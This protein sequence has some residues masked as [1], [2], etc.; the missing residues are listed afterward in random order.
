MINKNTNNQNISAG[1]VTALTA[2]NTEYNAR[3]F[4]GGTE[5]DCAIVRITVTKGSCGDINAFTVGNVV[6]S[7]LIAEVKGLSTQVK[8]K[9]LTAQIG[10]KVNGSFEYV[11]LGY[12]T[13]SE[14]QQTA[15]ST[16]ITAYGATI[17][18]TGNAFNAPAT[19]TLANIASSIATS[20][21]ALAGRTVNVTFGS[22]ITTS[23][24]ITASMANLTVYQ[25]LMI[26][27]SVVGGYAIDTY[28]GNI[29][30]CRF[31]DTATLARDTSTMKN[32]PVVDELNFEVNGV[33][34]I[35]EEATEDTE[36]VQFPTTPTGDE[37]LI[38]QN[39]YMT[40]D[41]YT[42]Y[43]ATLVNYEY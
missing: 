36:A 35:V 20:V 18:K 5:L 39:P 6:G 19:Q 14:T 16:T 31:S 32:L 12:F 3:L 17:T 21:S 4:D 41:L 38:V 30:I 24:V 26:L 40:Q 27:A 7:T 28:D 42:S 37:N 2:D 22:E 15:Y 10:V 9:E 23:K 34:C 43:L 13:V 25:A 8:G 33:L 1:F 29:K 11:N